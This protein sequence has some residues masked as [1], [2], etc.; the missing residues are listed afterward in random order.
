M[1]KDPT[2]P[3]KVHV[4]Q[5]NLWTEKTEYFLQSMYGVRLGNDP[6]DSINIKPQM[7]AIHSA[8]F[9]WGHIPYLSFA[10]LNGFNSLQIQFF[11]FLKK[12]F[13]P[14]PEEVLTNARNEIEKKVLEEVS[15]KLMQFRGKVEKDKIM[16][17]DTTYI[18]LAMILV[19]R[20][21]R[22]ES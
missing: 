21:R 18:T 4:G 8:E 2:K 11:C 6:N 10:R 16:P 13:A 15:C 22:G 9:E 17:P 12:E 14:P 1:Q 3:I 20:D 7:W 5:Q 19:E